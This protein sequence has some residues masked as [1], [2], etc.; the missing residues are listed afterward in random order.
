[1]TLTETS[2]RERKKEETRRRIFDA[3]ISLFRERGFETT[4]VDDITEKADVARGTFFNYFPRKE[5]LLAYLSEERLSMA[6][7]NA[8][9]L[10]ASPGS[11]REKLVELFLLAASAYEAD[12]ELARFVFTEWMKR[13]FTP[14]RDAEARWQRL[15]HAIL[16]QGRAQRALRDD[17]SD[18]RAEA[19]LSGI[20]ITTL[21]HWTCAADGAGDSVPSLRSELAARLHLVMDA[22][23][24]PAGARP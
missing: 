4:T 10:L 15:L 19:L 5:A 16:A 24:K 13:G 6:E 21:Y 8:S 22:I 18:A 12:R 7:E 14:T 23:E 3:A 9:A 2:R 20:Y 17:V 1:M 11:P